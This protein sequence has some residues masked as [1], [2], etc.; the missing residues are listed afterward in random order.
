MDHGGSLARARALFPQAPEPWVDLSTGISPHAYPFSTLPAKAFQRLPEPARAQELLAAASEAYGAPSP[1]CL[2]AAPGTQMLLPHIARLIEPGRTAVLAP[3]YAEH[4][5]AAAL[6]GHE[7]VDV[8]NVEAL[9]EA[10]LAVVVNPNNPD[11]RIVARNDLLKLRDRLA[12]NGGLLVVDEAFMD[13]GSDSVSGDV[14]DGGLVVLRSFGKFYGMAGVRLGFAL[15]APAT[16]AVLA[17]QLGPWAVSG[18]ALEIGIEALRDREWR[19]MHR[20]R[21]TAAAAR[22]DALLARHGVAVSGGTSLYRFVRMPAA[23]RLF[24]G[25]GDAGIIVRHFAERPH[26]LRIGLPGEDTE[27][28]RLDAALGGWQARAA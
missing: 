1:A 21:L 2:V 18:P 3:T 5:R 25:L 7:V 17:A 20:Q 11:G 16:A 10:H 8:A 15:A 6:A 4:A 24:R 27:W 28:E 12:A 19:S 23:S 9:G 14:E 26:D 22:L 13:V